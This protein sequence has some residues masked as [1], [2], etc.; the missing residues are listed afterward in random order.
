M[1]IAEAKEMVSEGLNFSSKKGQEVSTFLRS[2][3]QEK[4]NSHYPN[5]SPIPTNILKYFLFH[6]EPPTCPVCGRP[7][8]INKLGT[9]FKTYCDNKA[10][11]YKGRSKTYEKNMLGK[12]GVK[13][14]S[15]VKEFADRREESVRKKYGVDN[16]SQVKEFADKRLNTLE[17]SGRSGP[18]S[19]GEARKKYESTCIERFGEVWATSSE[20]V[21]AKRKKTLEEIPSEIKSEYARR[22]HVTRR[23][24]RQEAFD[25][26]EDKSK[27]EDLYDRGLSGHAI[28]ARLGVHGQ[29]VY[30]YLSSHEIRIR[31]F[32]HTSSPEIEIGEFI[33]SI[34]FEVERNAKGLLDPNDKRVEIDV[35]VPSMRF[36]IEYN[37]LRYHSTF[38]KK[39]KARNCHKRKHDLA[40][41]AG[42]SLISI[43]EDDWMNTI[44]RRII[45]KMISHKLGVSERRLYAR[46]TSVCT[47]PKW[48]EIAEFM[49][50]THIQGYPHGTT[51][52]VLV[53]GD[54]KIVA[55]LLTK[56]KSEDVIEVSRY[57][58]SG[59]IG[60]FSKCLKYAI[61]KYPTANKVVTYADRMTSNGGLYE[62]TGFRLEGTTSPSYMYTEGHYRENK[63]NFRRSKLKEKFENFDELLSESENAANNGFYQIFDA[64]L[65]RYVLDLKNEA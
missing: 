46:K 38:H 53:D 35:Y 14:A 65:H 64:G 1:N 18:L 20:E 3:L 2:E 42:I 37:G 45:E 11:M 58:S 9:P 57:A 36:G 47:T 30:N 27:L 56:R 61:K 31:D 44:K 22:G 50:K 7:C 49:E 10:C 54:K 43:W 34:G 40:E 59:V 39:E 24:G 5:I 19:G 21:K 32:C 60:G 26:L 15:Q 23:K 29:T 8:A 52:T 63:Q 41:D 17:Q 55:C 33:E 25:I 16:V 51:S 6:D 4:V 12:Y 13:N 28:A 48:G 62:S